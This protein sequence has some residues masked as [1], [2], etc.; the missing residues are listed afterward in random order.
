[1]VATG[2]EHN[3]P[4]RLLEAT[5]AINYDQKRKIV[6]RIL[7]HFGGDVSGKRFALWGLSFKPNTDDMREAPSLTII[8]ELTERGAT[9]CAYDPEATNATKRIIGDQIEYSKRHYDALEG[10]D[11]LIIATEWNKF[12]EPDFGFMREVLKN[13]VIFDGRNL[14]ELDSMRHHKFT[15]YSIGR[16]VVK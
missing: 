6:P 8:K 16:P 1:L 2:R 13:P 7:E 15:Y 3:A 10:A 4:Q 11:A 12:R 9:I 14:Y 5:E